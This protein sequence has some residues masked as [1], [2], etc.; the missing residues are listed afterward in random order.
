[1]MTRS[2]I[3]T[4]PHVPIIALHWYSIC[5]ECSQFLKIIDMSFKMFT[6]KNIY[7]VLCT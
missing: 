5:L 7:V 3:Q 6:I 4:T 1:M 2:I